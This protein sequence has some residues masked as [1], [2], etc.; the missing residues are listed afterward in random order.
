MSHPL[1]HEISVSEFHTH[2]PLV[3]FSSS[4]GFVV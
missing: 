3:I 1:A 4:G 2:T